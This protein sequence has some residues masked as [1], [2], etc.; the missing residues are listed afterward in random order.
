MRDF[1]RS[2]YLS[3]AWKNTRQA[4]KKSVGGLCERCLA[5]GL[6]KAGEI[7]HHKI[8]ITPDNIDKTD[9]LLD[10]NNLELVCREC[11]AEEHQ[12]ITKRFFVDENGKVFV[13][14]PLSEKNF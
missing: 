4:Y 14:S 7:V 8:H 1:A 11:H 13:K 3:Q 12:R 2:F 5:K 6:Y 10:W 9:I